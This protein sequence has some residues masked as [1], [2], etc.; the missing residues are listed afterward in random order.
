MTQVVRVVLSDFHVNPGRPGQIE[1]RF[2]ISED[3]FEMRPHSPTGPVTVEDLEGKGGAT[4]DIGVEAVGA[5]A[6]GEFGGRKTRILGECGPC[7]ELVP[8]FDHVGG[9]VPGDQ[10]IELAY[11][12]G[13]GGRLR[14]HPFSSFKSRVT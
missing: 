5:K 11:L 3:L 13:Q 12:I 10:L 7:T 8:D 4:Q 2:W 9:V 6:G 1:A 14:G